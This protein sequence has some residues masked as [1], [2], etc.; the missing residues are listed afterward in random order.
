MLSESLRVPYRADDALGTILVGTI[1][2]V[3]SIGLFIGWVFLLA[4]SL[5]LGVALTPVILV[6]SLVIRGY[7]LQVVAAGIA[8]RPEAP[9]FVRWG[10][11]VRDGWKSVLLSAW[12][13]LPAAVLLGLAVGAGVATVVSPPGFEGALQAVA[14]VLI[15]VG[16]FGLFVYGLSYAYIRPAARAVLASSGSLRAALDFRRVGRLALTGDYMAGWL[17]GLGI[18]LAGPALLIPLF[19]FAGALGLLDPLLALFAV[20]C[21]LL[22]SLVFLFVLRMSAAWATG[23]GAALGLPTDDPPVGLRRSA[24]TAHTPDSRSDGPTATPNRSAEPPVAIQV[25][26]TVRTRAVNS[27]LESGAQSTDTDEAYG[28]RNHR[29]YVDNAGSRA[30]DE[31]DTP[32]SNTDTPAHGVTDESE[33]QWGPTDK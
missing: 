23:R 18:L 6:G 13:L 25:G 1:L 8:N 33:F 16:G 21:V 12:Y 19:A 17:I 3:L 31:Q 29:E 9:S 7:L 20:L 28:A 32:E 26:R 30:I 5:P 10:S 4:V 24:T 11:L 22:G 14:A 2:T 27:R 15:M